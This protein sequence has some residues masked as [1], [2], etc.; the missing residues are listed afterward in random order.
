[1][2]RLSTLVVIGLAGLLAGCGSSVTSSTQAPTHV[3]YTVNVQPDRLTLNVGDYSGISAVVDEST[4]NSS[5]KPVAPP[6]TIKFY[7]SDARV[8]VSPSGSICAG[9]WDLKYELCSPALSLPSNPVTI[10]AY[11]NQHDVS[12]STQ[13]FV[14]PRAANIT[15]TAPGYPTANSC[16]SQNQSV[17][18]I[19]QAFDSSGNLIPNCAT[20]NVAGCVNSLDYTWSTADPTVAGAGLY[21]GMVARNPGVTSIY[22]KLNGTVS[23]PLAFATCPPAAIVLE[24]SAYNK[25]AAAPP[26]STADM[27]S[28]A[29]DC[30]TNGSCILQKGST[31]YLTAKSLDIH[32]NPMQLV[33]LNGNPLNTLSLDFLSSSLLTGSFVSVDAFTSRFTANT[34]GRT[35]LTAA[36]TPPAC[37]PTISDFVAPTGTLVPAK[38]LGYGYP[39]YSNVIG[40]SVAGSSSSTVLVTGTTFPDGVTPVHRLLTYD[41]ESLVQTHP[42]GI[43]LANLPNSLVVAPNGQIA[44]V[45]SSEGLVVVNLTTYSSAIQVY[46]IVGDP[47][48]TDQIT[49]TVLGVSPDSRYVLISDIPNGLVFLLDTTV[50]KSATRYPIPNIRAVTFAT[51]GFDF[52][53][54]GDS[55]VYVYQ[56]DTFV[57]TQFSNGNSSN[58]TSLAWTP[59]GQSYFASG[60]QLTNYSTCDD[61]NPQNLGA[62]PV[63][64][65]STAIDGSP[66][67]FGLAG[68]E[69]L[70]YS[71]T[72]SSRAGATPPV[73]NVCLST[74]SVTLVSSL[75][76]AQSTLKCTAQQFTFSPRLEQEFVTG[77]DPLCTTPETAIHGY[78]LG[79]KAEITLSLSTTSTS[80]FTPVPIVPLSGGILNDGRKLYVG[81]MDG[82]NSTLLRRFDLATG[83]EEV[84]TQELVDQNGNPTTNPPTFV[85]V[86][87]ASVPLVPSYVAV[88]PK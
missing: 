9:Q 5:P 15:L 6:P 86:I 40:A 35:I 52:W 79:S 42:Q 82:K 71:V 41:S 27:D 28:T 1:M 50:A 37:N 74:V 14:H 43:E 29:A 63:D 58:V 33:D 64:L 31:K 87:P 84:V 62:G 39:I 83:T 54:G 25:G 56:G 75:P 20:S 26:Y 53:I 78:D 61:Q 81:T 8:S 16:V 72:S 21:G 19:A 70:D 7:T 80:T 60:S 2:N 55:G 30:G 68:S 34:S 59:D 3:T 48:N 23:V 49:G 65:A 11:D 67:V 44:Y 17:T 32:G 57:K 24:T 10:T 38:S 73:G 66:R 76:Q 18:Y 85:T 45:G 88:V 47:I 77:E 12:G 51:D 46:P 22:A 69:W 36:C 13:L 4:L